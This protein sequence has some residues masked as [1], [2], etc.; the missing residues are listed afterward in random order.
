[1]TTTASEVFRDWKK[2][3]IT[4]A[5]FQGLQE[6]KEALQEEL[7]QAAGIN[8]LQDRFAAGYIAAVNDIL[9]ISLDDI[10]EIE[11]T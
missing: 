3:G 8:P 11:S 1:M 6:R 2:Q 10:Q 5:V 9:N 7:G 4:K